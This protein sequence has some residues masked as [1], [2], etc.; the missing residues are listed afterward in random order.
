[1]LHISIGKCVQQSRNLFR[2]VRP[3]STTIEKWFIS[4]Q[5]WYDFPLIWPQLLHR[6]HSLHS[7]EDPT[8]WG[9][10]QSASPHPLH[11]PLLLDPSRMPVGRSVPMKELCPEGLCRITELLSPLLEPLTQLSW[12]S[13]AF[14]TFIF[15]ARVTC[16]ARLFF[17]FHLKNSSR[18]LNLKLL[19]HGVTKVWI[20]RHFSLYE[21]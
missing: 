5:L 3:T 7:L 14:I 10:D 16:G 4:G 21:I 6:T 17:S 19:L 2:F 12:P 18:E 1:M 9:L 20:H 13:L 8:K 15:Q 11:Y